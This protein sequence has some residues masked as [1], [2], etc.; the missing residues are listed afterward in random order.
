MRRYVFLVPFFT[1][2]GIVSGLTTNEWPTFFWEG[3]NAHQKRKEKPADSQSLQK[4]I[5]FA[6]G[7]ALFVAIILLFF[8]AIWKFCT[9]VDA[10]FA[11]VNQWAISAGNILLMC[12]IA[13]LVLV[14]RK[15]FPKVRYNGV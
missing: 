4:V 1:I 2:L 7:V 9:N 5:Y 14:F 13:V 11:Y 3:G 12:I 6:L 8:W 15:H 10:M